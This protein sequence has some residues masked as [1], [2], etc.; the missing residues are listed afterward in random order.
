M[1]KE[2]FIEFMNKFK[3]LHLRNSEWYDDIDKIFGTGST[4]EIISHSYETFV[5]EFIESQFEDKAYDSISFL[6][7]ECNWD[8]EEYCEKT[9]VD[10]EHPI[11]KDFGD[12][13]DYLRPAHEI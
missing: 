11:I 2:Y 4:E 9:L 10:G 3:V 5:I 13:Y 1:T 12:L 6:I 7:Y 8:F